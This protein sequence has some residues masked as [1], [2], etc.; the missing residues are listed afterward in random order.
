VAKE[1]RVA[2]VGCGI[3][4]WNHARV[5]TDLPDCKLVAVCDADPK[6]A[7]LAGEFYHVNAYTQPDEILKNDEIDAI[8]V[9]TPSSTH[10]DVGLQV[11]EHGKDL[12]VEKP[13]AV[14][15]SDAEKMITEARKAGVM[16]TVGFIERFNPGVQYAKEQLESGRVGKVVLASARRVSRWPTR[17]GDVGVV[18]DLAIHDIDIVHW[19]MKSEV[20]EVY[21]V[22]GSERLAQE[23]HANIVMHFKNGATGFI[24]TNW[25]TP[26]KV[27]KLIVT[28]SE[29]IVSVDYITQEVTVED[30]KGLF[31]PTITFQEPLRR[32]LTHFLDCVRNDTKPLV[33]GEDGLS[34]LEI[35]DAALKSSGVHKPVP[36]LEE[37]KPQP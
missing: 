16:L 30:E 4:G 32:E 10:K 37:A 24:E 25:L 7:K 35:A 17:I 31:S 23:D 27:R 14:S 15:P 8:T 13:M 11:M 9:C 18:K 5:F 12:L 3:W 1:V 28:G 29:A 21:A 36:L 34:A 22:I 2:V 19:L 33:S 20:Y 6:R 26:H